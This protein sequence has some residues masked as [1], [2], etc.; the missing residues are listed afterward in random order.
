MAL[1]WQSPTVRRCVVA[2]DGGLM[3]RWEPSVTCSTT[4]SSE[5]SLRHCDVDSSTDTADRPRW[6]RAGDAPV[7]RLALPPNRRHSAR[8]YLSHID[9]DAAPVA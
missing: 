6:S 4:R 8:G 5:T 2:S 7:D 3:P 9:F 1:S